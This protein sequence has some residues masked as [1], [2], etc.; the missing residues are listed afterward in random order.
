[1]S[2]FNRKPQATYIP[3]R[4]NHNT[5]LDLYKVHLMYLTYDKALAATEKVFE[6]MEKRQVNVVKMDLPLIVQ[7]TT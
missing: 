7:E 3:A 6:H 5:W 2:I 4:P 1:M